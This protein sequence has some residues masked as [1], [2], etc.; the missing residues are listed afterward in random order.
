MA[1]TPAAG[2]RTRSSGRASWLAGLVLGGLGGFL[3]LVVPPGGLLLV[4]VAAVLVVRRGKALPGLGGVLVGVGVIWAF[5]LGR[6][7]LTCTAEVGCF[8]PTI[9]AFLAIG[10]GLLAIGV[11]LSIL[12]VVR[13]IREKRRTGL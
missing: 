12:S 5:F 3:L 7:W 6:T 10:L 8:T 11:A 2:R 13:T 4:V 9:D 1:K